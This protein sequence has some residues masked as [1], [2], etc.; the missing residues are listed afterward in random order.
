VA[1]ATAV[2]TA[3]AIEVQASVLKRTGRGPVFFR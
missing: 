1:A 2:A 3:A